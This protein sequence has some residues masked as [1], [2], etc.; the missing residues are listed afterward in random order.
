MKAGAIEAAARRFRARA[1]SGRHTE[2]ACYVRAQTAPM[3]RPPQEPTGPRSVPATYKG[4]AHSVDTA[5]CAD[6]K[7]EAHGATTTA[8]P[9]TSLPPLPKGGRHAECR[10]LLRRRN[11]HDAHA[12]AHRPAQPTASLA[13]GGNALPRLFQAGRGRLEGEPGSRIQLELQRTTCV[14]A[15]EPAPSLTEAARPASRRAA[16]SPDLRGPARGLRLPMVAPSRPAWR[17][18]RSRVRK[19]T[20][21]RPSPRP[22]LSGSAHRTAAQRPRPNAAGR[23]CRKGSVPTVDPRRRARP[24]RPGHRFRKFWPDLSKKVDKSLGRK[25]D[26]GRADRSRGADVLVIAVKPGYNSTFDDVG[27]S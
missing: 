21:Q 15:S 24:A 1:K 22:A 10:L 3:H 16:R 14:I 23:R 7:A 12:Q 5:T 25:L 8:S 11:P 2:C 18:S 4:G 17:A 27:F 13:R 6:R 26:P 20:E 9:P 19:L